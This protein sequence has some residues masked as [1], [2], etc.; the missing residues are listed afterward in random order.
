MYLSENLET[1]VWGEYEVAVCGGGIAG[2]SAALAAARQG[3]KTVLLEQQYLLGGLA[4][5]GLV[6][7]YLPLCDGMGRQISFG[8]AEELLRLSIRDGAE[9]RYPENWLENK[10]TRTE[11]DPRFQVQFN[12]HLFASHAEALLLREGVDLLYGTRVTDVRVEDS[13][14]RCLF[15]ENKSGRGAFLVRSVVD[16]TGDCDVALRAGAP[17]ETFLA[18]NKLSSWYYSLGKDGYRLNLQDWVDPPAGEAEKGPS[19]KDRR[20]DGLEAKSLTEQTVLSHRS[21]YHDFLRK[22]KED[23]SYVPTCLPS[24]PQVR[25]TRKLRGKCELSEAD[26][27]RHCESSV[28]M[29]SNWRSRGPVY[30]VPFEALFCPEIRNLLCAGRCISTDQSLWNILRVIPCCA[31]TGEAAGTAAA[32]TDDLPRLSVSELQKRLRQRGVVLHEKDLPPPRA[33]EG[34]C[35]AEALEK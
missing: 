26:S 35:P 17:T 13:Y 7:I 23:P 25:M 5:A 16:A 9:A 2:I 19:P 34:P 32:M 10:G 30:E 20:F 28:G 1:P 4:T 21:V 31:V 3:K 24:I 33:G 27:H 29:V 12:P 18:G 6:T 22:R 11:C 15:V 8:I 14:I